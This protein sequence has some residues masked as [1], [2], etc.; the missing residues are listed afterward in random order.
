MIQPKTNLP[1]AIIGHGIG[2]KEIEITEKVNETK[3][4]VYIVNSCNNFPKAIELLKS[5]YYSM[6]NGDNNAVELFQIDIKYL[7]KDIENEK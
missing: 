1:W 4:L 7:L 5:L 3:D 2:T 6:R